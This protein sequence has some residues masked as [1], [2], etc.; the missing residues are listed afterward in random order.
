MGQPDP[1]IIRPREELMH[2]ARIEAGP[3]GGPVAWPYARVLLEITLD[4][5]DLLAHLAEHLAAQRPGAP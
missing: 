2:D 3:P 5:R 4:I 1:P